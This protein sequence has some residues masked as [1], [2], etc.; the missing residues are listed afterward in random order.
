[1]WEI[2][3][4][5]DDKAVLKPLFM[6]INSFQILVTQMARFLI[7]CFTIECVDFEAV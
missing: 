5:Q 3:Y 7:S 1:M 6:E 2:E 4:E